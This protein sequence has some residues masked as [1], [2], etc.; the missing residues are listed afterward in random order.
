MLDLSAN[1]H[2]SDT[3]PRVPTGH[4]NTFQQLLREA[5]RPISQAMQHDA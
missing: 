3:L 1:E 5:R 4:V 2:V